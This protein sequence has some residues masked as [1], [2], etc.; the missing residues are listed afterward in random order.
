MFCDGKCDVEEDTAKN[1]QNQKYVPASSL[2]Q[3]PK[4]KRKK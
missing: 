3:Q 4:Q 2:K 1:T